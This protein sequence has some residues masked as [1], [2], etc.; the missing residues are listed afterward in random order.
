VS[1]ENVFVAP[2]ARL[3]SPASDR[4]LTPGPYSGRLPRLVGGRM[5]IHFGGAGRI[6]GTVKEQGNPDRPL[7]RQVLLFSDQSRVLVAAT[8]SDASGHYRFDHLDPTQRYT[9]ISID[10]ERIYR[11]V[12]ADNLQPEVGP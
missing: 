2:L 7:S 11:A 12:I 3:Q 9:V 8:W 1:G 10:H 6:V 4:W 5:D